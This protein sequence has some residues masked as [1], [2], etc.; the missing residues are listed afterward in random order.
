MVFSEFA[1]SNPSAWAYMRPMLEENDGWAVFITTPRG[2]NHAFEMAKHAA[3][4]PGWFYELQTARDTEALTEDQLDEALA[5]YRALYGYE[6]GAALFRQEYLCDWQSAL[7]GS[8]YSDFMAAVRN[9][10]RIVECEPIDTEYVHRA[11]D[12][13]VG[14]DTSIWWF[15]AQPSGQLLILDHY[16]ASG[17]GVEHFRDEIF[18]R[19]TS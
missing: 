12:L 18:R 3:R 16:A 2:R 14:D 9:E 11:W 4:A 13:G 19:V 1:L 17:R 5:E 6:Q 7:L 8:F 10:G 15:Q